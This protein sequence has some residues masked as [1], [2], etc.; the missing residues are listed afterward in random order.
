MD[1][2]RLAGR[3]SL[4]DFSCDANL[5]ASVSASEIARSSLDLSLVFARESERP[6]RRAQVDF[7]IAKLLAEQGEA[8]SEA[9]RHVTRAVR[10]FEEN[11]EREW[12]MQSVCLKGT[13]EFMMGKTE[14]AFTTLQKYSDEKSV[15]DCLKAICLRD[16]KSERPH[17]QSKVILESILRNRPLRH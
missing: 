9:L 6:L 12:L 2:R 8:G 16:M 7:G 3:I 1:S 14:A 15:R 17:G 4:N 11:G 10:W 13:I 5:V